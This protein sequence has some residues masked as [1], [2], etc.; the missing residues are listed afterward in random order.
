M[1][2]KNSRVYACPGVSRKTQSTDRSLHFRGLC[3]R[4]T[5]N[6]RCQII[7]R[8]ACALD[9][10]ILWDS[11]ASRNDCFNFNAEKFCCITAWHGKEYVCYI[12]HFV[13][14]N[15]L[16]S[17]SVINTFNLWHIFFISF[18]VHV[19]SVA[20][21]DRHEFTAVLFVKLE[22]VYIL[23]ITN[24]ALIGRYRSPLFKSSTLQPK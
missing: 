21:S 1:T 2:S 5:R 19:H 8:I 4:D 15:Y 9:T 10:R 11:K 6:S 14:P 7:S 17:L 3:F 24:C 20:M 22:H 12:P 18:V 13:V 23:Q 16:E